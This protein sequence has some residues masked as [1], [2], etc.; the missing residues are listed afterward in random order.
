MRGIGE[1]GTVG[2]NAAVANAMFHATG[3]RVRELPTG[4][5]KLQERLSLN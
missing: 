2:M 4:I 1:I 5:P 3:K